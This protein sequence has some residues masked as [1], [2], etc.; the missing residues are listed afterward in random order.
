MFAWWLIVILQQF[1]VFHGNFI[2]FLLS[3][4]TCIVLYVLSYLTHAFCVHVLPCLLCLLP[5]VLSCLM[6]L[7]LSVFSYLRCLVS[8]VLSCLRYLVTYVLLGL[9]YFNC[10]MSNILSWISCLVAFV[11][12]ASYVFHVLDVLDFFSLDYG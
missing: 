1:L 6:C 10:I 8:Y 11:F 4:P 2:D 12:R 9:T 7:V 3:N 5:Y